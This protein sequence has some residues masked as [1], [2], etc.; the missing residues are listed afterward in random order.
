MS[1][2]CAIQY[3]TCQHF[4]HCHVMNNSLLVPNL[5]AC[6]AKRHEMRKTGFHFALEVSFSIVCF[7]A[8]IFPREPQLRGECRVE[9]GARSGYA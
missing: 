2:L 9:E 7:H 6:Y 4:H 8:A 1:T 3:E 5:I